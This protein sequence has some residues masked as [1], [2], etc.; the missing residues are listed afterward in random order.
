M[1][2]S[3]IRR[4]AYVAAFCLICLVTPRADAQTWTK[5][6]TPPPVKVSSP[7]L[8]ADG[9][10]IFQEN[11]TYANLN[12]WYALTP[13]IHGSY[14]NGTW[15]KLASTA[16][17]YCPLYYASAV[18]ADG[19]FAMLGGEY[20]CSSAVTDTNQGAVYDPKTNSWGTLLAPAGIAKEGDAPSSVLA[21]GAWMVASCALDRRE[22][23]W[24]L[25][26]P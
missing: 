16:S 19:R 21:N 2:T 26:K 20:N 11:D 9:R 1:R 15:S 8:L 7:H 5:L 17:T 24:R 13:D 18:L 12:N 25:A 22:T 6:N 4:A 10:V 14:Q 23:T 3:S